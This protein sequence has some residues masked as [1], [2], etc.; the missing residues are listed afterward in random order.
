M[1]EILDEVP[2]EKHQGQRRLL[3]LDGGGIRGL[4]SLQVL[5][6]LEAVFRE[7]SND[8]DRRLSDYFDYFAGTSTGALI[9][10]GLAQGWTVERITKLY[11]EK[12]DEI[13]SR[14]P[15]YRKIL[16][17]FQ[18]KY[19]SKSLKKALQTEFG[20]D[21]LFGDASFKSLLLAVMH[22]SMSDS[23]WPLSNNPDAKYNDAGREDCNMRIPL[24]Q[25]LRASSAAPT[26]FPPEQI[27]MPGRKPFLFVDGGITP[28]NNPALQ[29]YLQ[30]TAPAYRLGWPAD[31]DRM[32]LVSIGTGFSPNDFPDLTRRQMNLIHTAKSMPGTFM[33]G[34][35]VQQ[36]VVCRMLGHC[37]AGPAIDGEIGDVLGSDETRESKKFT[38]VRYNA[39]LSGRGMDELGLPQYASPDSIKNLRRLDS[40]GEESIGAL[41]EV[42]NAVAESQVRREHFA[43]FPS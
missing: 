20:K 12:G 5:A 41:A 7:D 19:E 15:L 32:L 36:D 29:V 6:R 26:F 37:L 30:A 43:G 16:S 11:T 22:N 40:I 23:P 25:V 13:F 17:L 24:W 8:D 9:A 39:E 38:Y 31:P 10:A 35:S 21:T 3:A 14:V 28:A 4:L 33:N 18:A 27:D 42:G 34:S 2:A 1:T